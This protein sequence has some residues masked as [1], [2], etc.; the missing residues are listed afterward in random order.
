MSYKQYRDDPGLNQSYLKQVLDNKIKNIKPTKKMLDGTGIDC[1]L[2]TPD[3]FSERYCVFNDVPT[4]ALKEEIDKYALENDDFQS[5][6]I[7]NRLRERE[8]QG[9]WTDATMQKNIQKY[10][11]YAQSII[12][13]ISPISTKDWLRYNEAV[14]LIKKSDIWKE[15]N[16]G[17]NVYQ[18]DLYADYE[19]QDYKIRCKGLLD[20]LWIGDNAIV[21]DCKFTTAKDMDEWM[22][23]A[24]SFKYPMQMAFY[25]M[26]VEKNYNVK[27]ECQWLVYFA[28]TKQVKLIK[29]HPFDIEVGKSGAKCIKEEWYNHKNSFKNESTLYGFEDALEIWQ[30]SQELKLQDFD[31]EA[32][33]CKNIYFKSIYFN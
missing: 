29:C 13:G 3:E 5:I 33:Y 1:L 12:E 17:T 4:G 10:E 24:R 19:I 28:Y 9:N 11:D 22:S 16:R 21:T 27:V 32:Y 8:Y 14:S 25:K 7:L 15:V 26:L 2:Y 30:Q 20:D 6:A 23:I 31:L 18:K